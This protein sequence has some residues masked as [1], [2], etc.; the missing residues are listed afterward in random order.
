MNGN[1][2]YLLLLCLVSGFTQAVLLCISVFMLKHH[3]THLFQRTFAYV[4]IMHS[5]GF[6]NNFLVATF[7]CHPCSEYLNSLLIF[8]DYMIVGGYMMFAVSL[9]FPNRYSL[10]QLS[11]IEIPFVTALVLFAIT[12]SPVIYPVV[13][14]FTLTAS[15]ALLVYLEY[16]IKRH[17]AMLRNNVGNLEYF[18]LRWSSILIIVLFVV[19][20]LWAF[21]SVS[22]LTWFSA[23]VTDRNLLF[24][25]CY[26]FLAIVFVVFVTRKIIQQQVFVISPEENESAESEVLE[27]GIPTTDTRNH[28]H[29]V[30]LHNNI[31]KI[32]REEKYYLETDLTLLKLAKYLGTNRQYL[33]NYINQEKHKTFYD[34]IN[35]FRLEEAERLLD[36]K[37]DNKACSMEEIATL[38]G[39]NSYTTFLRSFKKKN[40]QSPT[41][42]LKNK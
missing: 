2:F 31:D 17:T 41:Y 26:C 13:Q 39:Y 32:M 27:E 25:T 28:Y 37:N 15:T 10:R 29:K 23:S 24:D 18:D 16:S 8:Y 3:R 21:E 33:S 38:S 42:Y 11:L 7:W 1:V 14:I 6:F 40:G 36:S 4:L 12:A 19:Q 35:D 22:Q 9:I 34:Y 5:F 30:L 20:L